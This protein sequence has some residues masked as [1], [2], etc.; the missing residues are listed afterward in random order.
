MFRRGFRAGARQEEPQAQRRQGR[1]PEPD[2][3]LETGRARQGQPPGT[4]HR[5]NGPAG[6][7][8]SL[9]AE[10][11]GHATTGRAGASNEIFWILRE[12]GARRNGPVH[13]PRLYVQRIGDGDVVEERFVRPLAG[14][15]SRPAIRLVGWRSEAGRRAGETQVVE[16]LPDHGWALDHGEPRPAE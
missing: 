16:D 10:V 14:P 13:W 3:K 6:V 2:R 9:K 8:T 5:R 12:R 4:G 15:L 7:G 11:K 1:Q